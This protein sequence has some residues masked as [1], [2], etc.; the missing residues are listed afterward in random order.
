MKSKKLAAL[1][2]PILTV[3]IGIILFANSVGSTVLVCRIIGI[4]LL[5]SGIFFT[6]SS[7]LN[8]TLHKFG[9][10]PGAFQLIL[11][12]F[13]TSRPD[14][15][16][17]F[18]TVFIGIIVLV[19]SIGLLE[20]GLENKALG[21]SLWW[22]TASLALIMAVLG[23]IIIFNPFGAVSTVMKLAGIVIIIQGISDIAALIKADRASNEKNGD[24]IEADYTIKK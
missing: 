9:V 3:I 19:K 12:L 2:S 11:G 21:L 5:I 17:A 23:I 6:G 10:I 14:K 18:L 20:H 4:I 15:M 24:F 13:I 7:L 8:G 16:V 1:A 22:V